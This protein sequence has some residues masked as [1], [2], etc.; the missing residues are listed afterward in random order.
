[1]RARHLNDWLAAS[2]PGPVNL[3]FPRRC[4][5]CGD[6]VLPVGE[7]I[8]PG[9]RKKL[10]PVKEPRCMKC[11]KE[12]LREEEEYCFDCLRHP[13]SFARG[14]SVFNYTDEASDSMAAVKYKN[15]REYLDFY[16]E[17]AI[18]RLAEPFSRKRPDCL[19]PVPVHPKR[20][21]KRGFNQAG[22]LA[23]RIGEAFGIPVR[24]DLLVRVK[25]TSPQ[26]DLSPAERLKNLR[27]AF[28]AGGPVPPGMRTAMIVDDIY[29]TG[30]TMEACTRI[31]LEAGFSEVS[32][33]TIFIGRGI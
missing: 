30:A 26:K 13:G 14:Y 29:T 27:S 18:R 12:L 16:G 8:C 2:F 21:R 23:D 3:L 25:N 1:M 19:I 20:L 11:G 33:F 32:F 17:E 6:I 22:V 31:L 10:S 28:R 9:C 4:P 5:V 7:L 24:E 15:R